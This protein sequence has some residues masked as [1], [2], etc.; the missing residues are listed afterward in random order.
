MAL[1]DIP[2]KTSTTGDPSG[3]RRT[4]VKTRAALAPT[5]LA[6][7]ALLLLCPLIAR[8]QDVSCPS[9][10]TPINAS[11]SGADFFK[12]FVGSDGSGLACYGIPLQVGS[13]STAEGDLNST[14]YV[15][16]YSITNALAQSDST[17]TPNFELVIVGTFP[18]S[19]YFSI[20]HDDMH[21]SSAQHLADFAIDP[22]GLS[23]DSYS[24]PFKNENT[25]AAGQWYM[26]PVSLGAIPS[27]TNSGCQIDPFEEDNLLD[28][29]QRHTSMDWNTVV[30]GSENGQPP[31]AHSWILPPTRMLAAQA[32]MGRTW[33]AKSSP[34]A[35]C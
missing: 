7:C 31:S 21:Y 4:R 26:A 28:A 6:A 2:Y 13:G 3:K 22:V 35:T 14:Y 12:S 33:P 1:W 17:T 24:N 5:A 18:D 16:Y 19:R 11:P 15:L 32:P 10:T 9:P 30:Q 34:A 20:T 23:G 27:S 8:P 29:T 25:Y